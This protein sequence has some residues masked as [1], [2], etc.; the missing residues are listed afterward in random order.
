MKIKAVIVEDESNAR[1][2]LENML[3]FYCH[4]IEIAGWAE[5]VNKAS[6]LINNVSPQLLFLD[7]QIKGG[8]SFDVLKKLEKKDVKIIFVTAY[9]QYAIRAIKLSAVDYLLKPLKPDELKKAVSKAVKALEDEEHLRLQFETTLENISNIDKDKKIILNTNKSVYV[10]KISDLIRCES[11][12]N[13]TYVHVR[14]K[15]KIMISKT[16]KEFEEML[17]SYGFF[18]VHQSHL[19]NM[20][21]VDHYLKK[22]IGKVHLQTGDEI[23]V[24]TRKKDEFLR[25]LKAF[26]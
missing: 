7:V 18:R 5:S 12:E 19:V 8:T 24:S 23:P 9:D 4:E 13:Y 11:C 20:Q 1:K 17:T 15:N 26:G 16:L 22:G 2:A 14:G 6:E 21:F 3:D 25:F 10:I